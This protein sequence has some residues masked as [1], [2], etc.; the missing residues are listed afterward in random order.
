MKPKATLR[1]VSKNIEP[2]ETRKAIAL[3][4]S[5]NP[6][7]LEVALEE[8]AE[9]TSRDFLLREVDEAFGRLITDAAE[10]IGESNKPDALKT[11]DE[12]SRRLIEY[13]TVRA[14]ILERRR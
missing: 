9:N 6:N 10:K 14:L 12:L 7:G 3:I 2:L 13:C 8:V 4:R 5:L 1:S 11:A